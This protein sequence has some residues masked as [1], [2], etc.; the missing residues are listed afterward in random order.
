ME[1]ASELRDGGEGDQGWHGIEGLKGVGRLGKEKSRWPE[2][3]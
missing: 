3:G 2:K 1:I